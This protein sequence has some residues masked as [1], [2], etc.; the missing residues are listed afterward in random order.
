MKKDNTITAREIGSNI[1]PALVSGMAMFLCYFVLEGYFNPGLMK[2][3][4]SIVILTVVYIVSY[5]ILTKWRMYIQIKD[6]L[7][8]G[9]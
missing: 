7:F 6:L 4:G 3:A 1:W 9:R 5:G 2:L 8:A